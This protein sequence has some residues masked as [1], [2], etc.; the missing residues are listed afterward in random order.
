[1]KVYLVTVDYSLDYEEMDFNYPKVFSTQADAENDLRNFI[2][3]HRSFIEESGWNIED[4]S[5]GYFEAYEDGY[6]PQNHLVANVIER[7]VA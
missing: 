5:D 4:D 7:E 6:Y 2:G 3:D 1:M